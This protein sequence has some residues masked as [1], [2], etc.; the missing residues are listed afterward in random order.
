MKEKLQKTV[1]FLANVFSLFMFVFIAYFN[2]LTQGSKF[3][4]IIILLL[5]SIILIPSN[6]NLFRINK[7]K[8]YNTGYNLILFLTSFY[9]TM[10]SVYSILTYYA[11][12][13]IDYGNSA[14]EYFYNHLIIMV[15][16]IVITY[17]SSF[18]VKKEIIKTK[19][20]NSVLYL[21]LIILTSLL[22]FLSKIHTFTLICNILLILLTIKTLLGFKG[23]FSNDNVRMSYFGIFVLSLISGNVI[24]A[25]I[26][27]LMFFD[28]DVIGVN[29]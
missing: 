1:Y 6:I 8:I 14:I 27:S 20:D 10:I 16:L 19:E 3:T 29:V 21:F 11:K 24:S 23:R 12:Y 17:I 9:C 22:P 2:Y 15:A 28:L 26:I 7:K 13:F 5:F 25:V 18:F 4:C